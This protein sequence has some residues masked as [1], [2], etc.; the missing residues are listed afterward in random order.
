VLGELLRERELVPPFRREVDLFIVTIG[1]ELRTLARRIARE[2]REK[3]RSVIY[4]LRSQSVRK[5]FSQ[6][7][8]EGRGKPWS[9]ARRRWIAAWPSSGTWR[10]AGS[11]RFPSR[12]SFRRT[13][14]HREGGGVPEDPLHYGAG[15]PAVER[16]G[17]CAPGPGHAGGPG[18][19]GGRRPSLRPEAGPLLALVVSG[20]PPSIHRAGRGGG[21]E[22]G[23]RERGRLP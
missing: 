18:G 11:G 2:Q 23:G 22:A 21:T 4:P 10:G 3:G 15:D 1:E 5:Q 9:W 17:V 12:P 8:S 13:P 19:R 14:R 6:A 20:L 7:G 16:A